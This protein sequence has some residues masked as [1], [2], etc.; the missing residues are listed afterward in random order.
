MQL[1]HPRGQQLLQHPPHKEGWWRLQGESSDGSQPVR[2]DT[3]VA[4]HNGEAGAGDGCCSN[5]AES[6]CSAEIDLSISKRS[7]GEP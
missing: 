1:G 2:G 6:C 3:N 7:E 5:Y 4:A